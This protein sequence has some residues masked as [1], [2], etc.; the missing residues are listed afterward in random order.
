MIMSYKLKKTVIMSMIFIVFSLVFMQFLRGIDASADTV[1]PP[2]TTKCF[3]SYVVQSGDS[4]WSIAGNHMDYAYTTIND[5]IQ[6]IIVSNNLSSD[7][8]IYEGELL[9]LPYYSDQDF[10]PG[11]AQLAVANP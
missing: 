4:L 11:D 10:V 9:I 6:D 7:G 1:I 8:Y 5:Y 2:N 3:K